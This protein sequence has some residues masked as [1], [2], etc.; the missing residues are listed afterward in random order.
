MDEPL[1]TGDVL[2]R[3]IGT[4]LPPVDP[5]NEPTYATLQRMTTGE[6]PD[7][8]RQRKLGEAQQA[9]GPRA[10]N[11]DPF[12]KGAGWVATHSLPFVSS[13]LNQ[14]LGEN[15]QQSF[16]RVKAGTATEDDYK[17]VASHQQEQQ[18][19]R[20]E[21]TP[22]AILETMGV[23]PAIAG[24]AA[25]GVAALRG[26]GMAGESLLGNVAQR[27][28]MTPAMPSLWLDQSQKRAI[29]QGGNWYDPKNVAPALA[30]GTLQNVVLGQ[31]GKYAGKAPGG[32]VGRVA[33]GGAIGTTET[34]AVDAF[35]GAVDEALPD[36]W[37][38][39][40]RYGLVGDLAR[41]DA[42][43]AMKKAA[44]QFTTFGAFAAFHGRDVKPLRDAFQEAVDASAKQGLAPAKTAADIGKINDAIEAGQKPDTAGMSKP[45]LKYA[46]AAQEAMKPLEKATPT[47]VPPAGETPPATSPEAAKADVGPMREFL[48]ALGMK[49]GKMKD[50]DVIAQAEKLGFSG[51][52]EA[53]IK[54]LHDPAAV[55]RQLDELPS[56]KPEDF[57]NDPDYRREA[58]SARPD[59]QAPIRSGFEAG[60]QLGAEKV[61]PA[62]EAEK[63]ARAAEVGGEGKPAA[64]EGGAVQP[65]HELVGG[66]TPPKSGL[67]VA[68]RDASG[69][70][71]YGQPGEIHSHLSERYPRSQ[72]GDWRDVGFAGPDGKFLTRE[73]AQDTLGG[74]K[75]ELDAMDYREVQQEKANVEK[76]F[77]QQ[78]LSAQAAAPHIKQ[79]EA[80]GFQEGLRTGAQDARRETSAPPEIGPASEPLRPEPTA[81]GRPGNERDAAGHAGGT[82]R[83]TEQPGPVIHQQLAG[84]GTGTAGGQPTPGGAGPTGV[85]PPGPTP[86]QYQ[87]M[88]RGSLRYNLA[89]EARNKAIIEKQTN[90]MV[91]EYDKLIANSKNDA[92]RNAHFLAFT[93][94]MENVG[95]SSLPKE[96]LDQAK[97]ARQLTD[98]VTAQLKARNLVSNYIEDYMGHLWKKAGQ[99]PDGIGAMLARR[100][101]A[102]KES[103]TKRRTIPTYRDGI[104]A[105]LEPVDWNPVR[106]LQ[107]NLFQMN[108]A[109]MAHDVV[110]YLKPRGAWKYVRL[111]GDVPQDF[112]RVEDKIATV[113]AKGEAKVQEWFD[114]QQM[115]GLEKF[116]TGIG[117]NL[118]RLT[119]TLVKGNRK[120]AGIAAGDDVTTK[121]G[122]PEEVLAHE[123]GH[124][125]D[126]RYGLATG[127]N[128]PAMQA[129]LAQLADLRASGQVSAAHRTYLQLPSER[130]ANLVAAYL[131]APELLQQVAPQSKAYLEALL[132]SH[133]ELR[134]LMDIKPSLELGQRDQMQRLAGP[135]LMGHYYMPVKIAADVNNHLSPGLSGRSGA[136]D[137]AREA[138][139]T[140]N[141]VQLGLSAFHGGFELV[142]GISSGTALAVVQ[143]TR[144]NLVKAGGSFASA[145]GPTAGGAAIG[146]AIGGP[147]GVGIGA[148][149]GTVAKLGSMLG[150][151]NNLVR[152]W[153]SPGTRGPEAAAM[154][155][156][157]LRG[158]WR[159]RMDEFYG[160]TQ[161]GKFR[162]ALT[163]LMAGDLK[164]SG[165]VMVRALPALNEIIS[166]PIMEWMVPRMKAAVASDMAKYELESN[167][168]MTVDQVQ[169]R[170]GKVVDS[171]DNRLGQLA[172]DNL[173]WNR[174]LKD[175][176]MLG[177]RSVG[178]NLG[179]IREIGGGVKDVPKSIGGLASG[180]GFTHRTAYLVGMP[181]ALGVMGAIYQYV[182]TGQG[183][184]ELLDMFFPK[185]GRTRKDST[186]DRVALPSYGRDVAS[187]FNRADEGPQK[188]AQNL[189]QMGKH[190]IN[191][192]FSTVREMLDN[193]DF[194]GMAIHDPQDST[195]RQAWDLANHAIKA[196]EPFAIR[197]Y[198]DQKG[199]GATPAQA[200]QGF[201]GITPANANVTRTAAEQRK[202]ESER[203]YYKTPLEK[204]R[205]SRGKAP[206]KRVVPIK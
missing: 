48:A 175:T 96:V 159:G 98:E 154:V 129:E 16:D 195:L 135:I 148:A 191:P 192:L 58:A 124:V 166:K 67:V 57:R 205:E 63:A 94:A 25:V 8:Y 1:D 95:T 82:G 30:Y 6:S 28:A 33:A 88:G 111:G 172:Y 105:G 163:E 44:V 72:R 157:M 174:T 171:V 152:E 93:D 114:K 107:M 50:A 13:L 176:L 100:P 188:V 142:D 89:V 15:V 160:G 193:E 10:E 73:Q 54:D 39:R 60:V 118:K 2:G 81:G 14:K 144:G 71:Y 65:G 128:S 180:E 204:L 125:I 177:V 90:G 38:V 198:Q 140:L 61:R 5:A 7:E 29:E 200:A 139:N 41:G 141:G 136:Y 87:A 206:T 9:A 146:G 115:E 121:F 76:A 11:A 49:H 153:E 66:G 123:I 97:I 143:A 45:L 168:G 27:A 178:W 122:T 120:V 133:A 155:E 53:G 126:D 151:G 199:H 104:D 99:T 46:D 131:H 75:G 116:A 12:S 173:F 24:E 80:S 101:F 186:A 106:L 182:A 183:P 103:F 64:A 110:E 77:R 47:E 37:K 134:P 119:S 78:G 22:R 59:E 202:M 20:D 194:Y 169:D 18:R 201:I 3:M 17:A 149:I 127:M 92:E 190:K 137:V 167:P 165:G 35:T 197:S 138:A 113:F 4:G 112:A 36:A 132:K 170:M 196:F 164:K 55:Q 43:E 62:V 156:A 145:I 185:T 32:L 117:I 23:L 130:A 187:M 181:M 162:K 34:A 109:I 102:G 84:T 68:N 42:G 56:A 161:L 31:I 83:D 26:V 189:Y 86:K 19:S 21:S 147:V 91:R 52:K 51:F 70:V 108:K 79:A 69:K 85:A 203:E 150:K 179:T 40:T 74:P 184:Q 158:G